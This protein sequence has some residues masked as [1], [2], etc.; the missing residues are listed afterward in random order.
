[1]TRRLIIFLLLFFTLPVSA[2][3]IIQ[4]I[5]EISGRSIDGL[6]QCKI[7]NSNRAQSA[8]LTITVTERKQGT[9]CTIKLPA[10]NLIQGTNALPF[11]VAKNASIQFSN[12]NMGQLTRINRLFSEG[13]YDYCFS[14]KLA[15]SD[16]PDEQCFSYLLAP[17]SELN[18]S[19]PNNED[20]ICDTRPLF[21]WQPLIPGITGSSYQLVLTEIKQG[22][23][24][25]EALNYN[26][27]VINQS[28]INSPI[29]PYPAVAREL[30]KGKQYAWQVTAYKDQTI[31][32]RS[33]IWDFAVDCQDT[34]KK[35][36]NDGYRNIEDL[37]KGNY[38]IAIGALKFAVVN[39]YHEEQL[40]YEIREINNNQKLIKRL[41][42]ITLKKGTN[43][44]TIDLTGN[45]HFTDAKY[46]II[47]I[48][49][50]NGSVKTLR[51]LYQ[52]IK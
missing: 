2:Q 21:T 3:V 42:K 39:P 23:N 13:D 31:L 20:K 45:S 40:K 52:D 41:P 30:Q 29:L 1:M 24:A 14:I 9:I 10:F 12:N 36:V 25:T 44:I 28:F 48:W 37:S 49:L 19:E 38:Y 16:L 22:Q 32:N 5:P 17:F 27:P 4:F 33:E 43:D 11:S 18:L 51:F 8:L 34:V 7:V 50:P 6:F 35:A 47:K 46:Y 26:V 15:Q